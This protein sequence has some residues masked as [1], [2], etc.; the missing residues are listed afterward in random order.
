MTSHSIV[1]M[2]TTVTRSSTKVLTTTLVDVT[3]S[4]TYVPLYVSE[5]QTNAF[6]VYQTV[7]QKEYVKHTSHLVKTVTTLST[8]D[9][10][11]V[12]YMQRLF[13]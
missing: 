3:S 1:A 13:A 12:G 4:L 2:L 11:S 7:Y 8:I 5:V 9:L 10:C 6:P